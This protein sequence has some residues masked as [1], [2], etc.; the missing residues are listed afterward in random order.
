MVVQLILWIFALA[1]FFLAAIGVK[2]PKYDLV[3]GGLFF[4]TAGFLYGVSKGNF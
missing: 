1:F 2:S 3:A 4:L